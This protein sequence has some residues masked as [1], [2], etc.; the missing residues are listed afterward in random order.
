MSDYPA[1]KF[2]GGLKPARTYNVTEV[3]ARLRIS[4]QQWQ[5]NFAPY[6]SVSAVGKERFVAGAD[7]TRFLRDQAT[8]SP[9]S[10]KGRKPIQS[11]RT[12]PA[13]TS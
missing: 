3:I 7:V 6:L 1:E 8:D 10:P 12:E 4:P 2:L 5:K 9:Q 11:F 13:C